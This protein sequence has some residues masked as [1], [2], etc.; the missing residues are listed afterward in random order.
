MKAK[1]AI[2]AFFFILFS[3][4]VVLAQQTVITGKL[5]GSD[6]KT[7]PKAHV[8][9]K[10]T[11]SK[12]PSLSSL[13]A[14]KDGNYKIECNVTGLLIVEFTGANHQRKFVP[15]FVETAADIKLNV[16]LAANEYNTEFTD[17]KLIDDFK[18]V[19]P[20]TAKTF[21][22]QSDGT[23]LVEFE[24]KQDKVEYEI[25]GLEKN[26][27][28]I[29][30]TQSDDYV[31]D[32]DGDYHSVVKAKDGKVRIVFDPTKLVR[33]STKAEAIFDEK[34]NKLAAF[35]EIYDAIESRE[36]ELQQKI[37]S[38]MQK[39]KNPQEVLQQFTESDKAKAAKTKIAQ[40]K[41]PF[42]RQVLLL[43]YFTYFEQER[44]D[45]N[46]A[47]LAMDE[48]APSSPLWSIRPYLINAVTATS[49]R[50]EKSDAYFE[51]FLAENKNDDLKAQALLGAISQ[52]Q[53]EQNNDKVKQYL[54]ILEKNYPN[55]RAARIAKM[56][57]SKDENVKIGAP[58]PEF[59][60]VA[61]GESQ[62]NYSK[63]SMK[64]KY[65][66][67][68]F[69]ATWCG[70]CVGEM[71]ELHKAYEKF[72]GN[73]FE[74][75]SLSFDESPDDITEFRQAK[76]KMPWLHTFVT[77]GFRS[78]LAKRFGVLGIPKPILVDPSGK[79]IATQEQ[80]RGDN[81]EKTLTKVLGQSQ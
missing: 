65:Y 77:D 26:N 32:G 71:P 70:P 4:V 46:I 37:Q 61:F 43:D 48:I 44:K 29:N 25:F 81:L 8:H 7:M 12:I 54:D 15:L 20:A 72:K 40:E 60:V 11:D 49:K 34:N 19:N 51:K 31:Y 62:K 14:D 6:G 47:L 24:T 39:G 75:L 1:S 3:F 30:G 66:L 76:W 36:E 55:T 18:N 59:S 22:K 28:I 57:F 52:L 41:D 73:N 74:I 53:Q 38:A 23:Y 13:E 78:E 16:K 5:V 9:L 27:R 56:Q 68:D 58:V 45:E 80:L 79:I 42:I 17:L 33:A 10:S 64:G 63:E 2:G 67:I 69:W 50:K 21:Q 35:A